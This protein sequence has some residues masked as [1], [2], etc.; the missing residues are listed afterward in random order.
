MVNIKIPLARY[1]STRHAQRVEPM[2]FCCVELVEQHGSTFSSRRARQAWHDELYWLDTSKVLRSCSTRSSRR[3]GH[4]ER[5][6]GVKSWRDEASGI[7]AQTCKMLLQ[8]AKYIKIQLTWAHY[9]IAY[10]LTYLL[11]LPAYSLQYAPNAR[12]MNDTPSCNA[13]QKYSKQNVN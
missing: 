4:V 1:V 2:H 6:D 12:T 7:W 5:V 8:S 3:A 11:Y 10:L 13:L 9:K